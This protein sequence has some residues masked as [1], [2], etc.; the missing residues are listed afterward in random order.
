MAKQLSVTLNWAIRHSW[1][2]RD[3]QGPTQKGLMLC[4]CLSQGLL[5]LGRYSLLREEKKKGLLLSQQGVTWDLPEEIVQTSLKRIFG[6]CAREET[7]VT[8]QRSFKHSMNLSL[9]TVSNVLPV[10]SLRGQRKESKTSA[11]LFSLLK[12]HK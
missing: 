4:S 6:G 7:S 3:S 9:F 2:Q 12:C 8:T 5:H 1:Q 10:S 11:A